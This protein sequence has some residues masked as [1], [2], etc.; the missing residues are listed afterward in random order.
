MNYLVLYSSWPINFT[1]GSLEI[2]SMNLSSHKS[3][4]T[5]FFG[6]GPTECL[7]KTPHGFSTGLDVSGLTLVKR[8]LQARGW[9]L[10]PTS[11]LAK[12]LNDELHIYCCR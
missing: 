4:L 9:G 7:K 10:G 6:N 8:N 11:A 1:N 12:A 2:E 3:L 5:I